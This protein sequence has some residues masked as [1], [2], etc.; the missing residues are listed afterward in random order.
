MSDDKTTNTIYPEKADEVTPEI[1]EMVEAGVFYGLSKT[2]TNPK[3]KH[4]VL[5]NR[6][7]IEILNLAKTAE[8]MEKAEGFIK[9]AMRQGG[10]PIIVATQPA[11]S[12]IV[13]QMAKKIKVPYVVTRWPGGALTNFGIILKRIEYFMKLRSDLASGAFNQYTKKERVLLEKELNKLRGL[14]EGL[15][16]MTKLPDFLITIDPVLHHTAVREA[17]RIKIPVVALASVDTDP[18]KISYLVP[19]ND[20]ARKSVE[21][22][23]DRVEKAIASG[24]AMKVEKKE[25]TQG[26][27]KEAGAS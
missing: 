25:P 21:W 4:Y 7:G 15:E 20:N 19:G 10:M 2:K 26:A 18:D 27:V 12:E 14:F 8:A 5:V 22:F 17:N 13:L 3:M 16:M 23:F 1:I 6:G 24:L 11:A 9:E